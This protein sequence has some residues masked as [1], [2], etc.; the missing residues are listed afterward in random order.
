VTIFDQTAFDVRLDW[1]VRG[2]RELAPG[3]TTLVV[4]DVL[5][6]STSVE[7]A[8]TRGAVV[9]PSPS[10]DHIPAGAEGATVASRWRRTTNDR[11]YSLSPTSLT[12][13]AKRTRLVLP[14]PNGSLI[15]DTVRDHV[16]VLIGCLR[17][18][19]AVA[20]AAVLPIGLIAAGER[21]D[22]GEP[23]WALEDFLGAGVIAASLSPELS[24][25]PE[26]RAARSAAENLDLAEAIRVTRSGQELIGA[27]YGRDVDLATETSV[28]ET[29]PTLADGAFRAF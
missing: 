3:C 23:R 26:V 27:G 20:R 16:R 6:F 17:N 1:G 2:A 15:A 4:V 7:I 22:N 29:V 25:S 9:Y 21:W 8:V 5:S 24:A 11:P 14:S 18:A 19:A 28:S 13:I 10:E 12:A